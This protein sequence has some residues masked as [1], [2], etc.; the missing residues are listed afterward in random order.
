MVVVHSLHGI[1]IIAFST[2]KDNV[3]LI[4]KPQVI[5]RQ[6]GVKVNELVREKGIPTHPPVSYNI[7]VHVS[8][9]LHQLST[10]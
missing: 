7:Q 8:K 10:N 1:G 6:Q 3:P 4:A 5:N 9:V 2:P